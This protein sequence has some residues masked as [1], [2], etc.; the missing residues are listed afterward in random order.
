MNIKG[1]HKTK[2]LDLGLVKIE[3]KVPEKK[4]KP[5]FIQIEKKDTSYKHSLESNVDIRTLH[6]KIPEEDKIK[7]HKPKRFAKLIREIKFLFGNL[8]IFE[9]IIMAAIILLFCNMILVILGYNALYALIPSLLYIIIYFI[10]KFR[11]N[12]YI[13]VEQKF[14]NLNEKIRTAA[15]NLYLENPVVDELR[16]EVSRG[17]NEVE[18]ASFFHER[19][20]SYKILLIVLLCFG[21]ILLAKYDIEFDVN[22]ERV[23]GFID[24]GDGNTTGLLSDII[25]ATTTGPDDDIFGEE[26]LAKLGKEELTI[27]INQVGYEI[28]MDD[29][30]DPTQ[31]DFDQSLFPDDIGLESAEVYNKDILKEH[32]ELVKNYFK[33]MAEE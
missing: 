16:H 24:G 4:H 12:K 7:K 11:E 13:K 14:P 1:H 9:G 6:K 21:V 17:M 31:K 29:V 30:K 10:I 19:K 15:D 20:T 28:N 23:F 2:K 27:Q 33:N 25:S 18:Y 22:F 3:K 26:Q 32:K 5:K 8:I